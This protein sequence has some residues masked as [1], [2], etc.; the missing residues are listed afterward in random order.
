MHLFLQQ[1]EIF[2]YW[3]QINAD[4]IIIHHASD[5][6]KEEM[7]IKGQEYLMSKNKTIRIVPVGVHAF[8][9]IL[10]K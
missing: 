5:E 2:D 4:K 8:Q 9:F 6:A 7:K 1:E 3:R 10:N